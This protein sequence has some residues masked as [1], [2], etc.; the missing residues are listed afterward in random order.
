M[1]KKILSHE[2]PQSS[3][4]KSDLTGLENMAQ[5]CQLFSVPKFGRGKIKL[6]LF[7]M[8]IKRFSEWC[9]TVVLFK[10]KSIN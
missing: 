4:P 9:K 2:K 7:G 8:E 1:Y 10:N 3:G 5:S 6:Y